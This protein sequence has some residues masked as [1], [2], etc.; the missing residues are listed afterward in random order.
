MT[1]L[2][3][4]LGGSHITCA[5]VHKAQI[6]TERT[7]RTRALSLAQHLPEIAEAL[8]EGR[9]RSRIPPQVFLGI[10]VGY[11][12]IVDGDSGIIL[13]T[14]DK[15]GDAPQ[16]DL[17]AWAQRELGL[18]LRMEND[19]RLALLGEA[20]AGAARGARDV[21]LVML[22]TGVGGAAM[23]DGKLLRS[24]A[25]HAGAL[26]GH[27]PVN[28]RG[29]V[30]ACGAVGCAEAEASTAVL[31]TLCRESPGFAE[32]SLA[33]EEVLDFAAVFR[34]L[35]ADD[36]VAAK[37]FDHCLDVW[38][39][40]TVGLIH[41]YGPELVLF[42]GGV[43]RQGNLILPRIRAYVESHMWRTTAGLPRI[44]AAA[45]GRHAALIGGQ[46][47]FAPQIPT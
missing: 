33:R 28:F 10:A 4:D 47:L 17:H 22:G 14:L 45:L 19:A 35:D 41:A 9:T 38:C 29:R 39:T 31:P 15:Y 8:R 1:V 20:H 21:V 42:G 5:V 2:A 27:L 32:S 11:C 12:G 7:I 43:M 36:A 26:G 16:I 46:A 34:G 23:L 30:C 40:L 6:A 18:P 37:V 13:S 3:V 25:G 24:K 44:E